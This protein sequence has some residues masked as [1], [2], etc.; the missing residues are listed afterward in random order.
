[1][2]YRINQSEIDTRQFSLKVADQPVAIEP[3]VFDLVV[4][5][6]EHRQRVISREELFDKLWTGREV[7]DTTLSNHI[8]SARKALGD[9]AEHQSIIKTLRGRGYQ[10]IANVEIIEEATPHQMSAEESGLESV[11][12]ST[13]SVGANTIERSDTGIR[14]ASRLQTRL[15]QA[16]IVVLLITLIAIV[17]PKTQDPAV[18]HS[19]QG[20]LNRIAVLPFHSLQPNAKTDYLGFAMADQI[21]GELSRVRGLTVRGSGSIRQYNKLSPALDTLA[22]SLSIDYLLNGTYRIHQGI[23]SLNIELIDVRSHQLLWRETITTSPDK[24]FTLQAVVTD[25]VAAQLSTQLSNRLSNQ[26]SNQLAEP[27]ESKARYTA[28]SQRPS[29]ALAYE[30]YLRAIAAPITNQGATLAREMLNQARQ[31][32][33]NYTPILVALGQRTHFLS[34]FDFDDHSHTEQAIDYFHQALALTPESHQALSSLVKIYAETGQTSKAIELSRNLV[35]LNKND[36][37]AHF[38]LGYSYRY[39]G[40]IEE[41]IE[42]IKTAI[43]LD[44]KPR[45]SHTLSISYLSIEQYGKAMEALEIGSDTPYSLGWKASIHLHQGQHELA[46]KYLDRVIEMEPDSFWEYDSQGFRAY[47]TQDIETGLAAAQKLEAAQ[48]NDSEATFYWATI[49]ALLDDKTS[50]MRMLNKAVTNGYYNYPLFTRE[51]HLDSLRQDP[52]FQ[53]LLNTVKSQHQALKQRYQQL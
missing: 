4:Y 28:D 20:S 43:E 53:Q 51:T 52:E 41:S 40:L 31:L 13:L 39:A 26:P 42:H 35:K 37:Q 50:A 25:K 2:R 3:K 7:S 19:T 24:I 34:V 32:D 48:V 49:Y 15:Y 5:L 46:L 29:N 18:K 14:P 22:K 17:L 30:L 36:A 10:C 33:P 27:K 45:W 16:V 23:L 12:T 6:I 38:S 11:D 1:M 44:P 9:S 21:I 8:K 47:I